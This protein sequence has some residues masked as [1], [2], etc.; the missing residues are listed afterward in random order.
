MLESAGLA[1]DEA[2]P[3]LLPAH[4]PLATLSFH[5]AQ[6]LQTVYIAVASDLHPC[7]IRTSLLRLMLRRVSTDDAHMQ[8]PLRPE[9]QLSLN[10][11]PADW[12]D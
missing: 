6:R 11:S 12:A 7:C 3:P 2:R 10:P 8:T 9:C 4:A 1:V 5:P